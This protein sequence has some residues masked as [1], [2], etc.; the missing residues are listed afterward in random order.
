MNP[1]AAGNP[2]AR[3]TR[4]N[5]SE[6]TIALE[7]I[8]ARLE[9]RELA[10]GERVRLE[11]LRVV[12]AAEVLA[13]SDPDA[14]AD[15][16]E[17]ALHAWHEAPA[18]HEKVWALVHS[19]AVFLTAG[20]NERAL[21]IGREALALASRTLDVYD[22]LVRR[23]LETC[24]RA[25]AGLARVEESEGMFTAL[26]NISSFD[27]PGARGAMAVGIARALAS[28]AP[29]LALEFATRAV[30]LFSG[31]RGRSAPETV[32]AE[33]VAARCEAKAGDPSAAIER[34]VRCA[35]AA[36][37]SPVAAYPLE[38]LALL[39]SE[40]GYDEHAISAARDAVEARSLD[41]TVSL[42]GALTFHNAALVMSRYAATT[43][44][45]LE[46]AIAAY[47]T[48]LEA[49]ALAGAD[50]NVV[51]RAGFEASDVAA[52]LAP[53]G[54]EAIRSVVA[55]GGNARQIAAAI[56]RIATT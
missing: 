16:A 35:D 8:T 1:P 46:G 41:G 30:E 54:A 27:P 45:G 22:P 12:A 36:G 34:L 42:A 52:L 55:E 49:Y 33:V 21:E 47:A 25:L 39:Y 13:D 15:D 56:R 40:A 6:A 44:T 18:D 20:R 24:G 38:A 17:A 53:E 28:A 3:Y 32:D 23:A 10:P 48:A 26:A 11:C 9:D 37:K 2:A 31:D 7:E 43:G 51:T 19:A 29:H 14:A 4:T 50:E 5:M